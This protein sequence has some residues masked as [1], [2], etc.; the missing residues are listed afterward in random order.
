MSIN[1][2]VILIG[3]VGALVGIAPPYLI[4]QTI[5]L[6]NK[7]QRIDIMA[8]FIACAL[9]I[10]S[11]C[12]RVASHLYAQRLTTIT[13]K[14]LK[15]KLTKAIIPKTT[16]ECYG[17]A[18]DLI[19]GD[20][21]GSI[22]L[23]HNIYLD[24]AA[25]LSALFLALFIVFHYNPSLIVAPLSAILYIV[26]LK[27]LTRK[28]YLR[29]YE[30][31]V[32]MHTQLISRISISTRPS[33]LLNF[34]GLIKIGRK[35]QI[36][37]LQSKAKLALLELTSNFSYLIGITLLFYIGSYSIANETLSIGDFVSAAIYLERILMPTATLVSIYY[38][39]GEARY[40]RMRIAR[41]LSGATDG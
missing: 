20:V 40:R 33:S 3:I 7:Y 31:Y 25:S 37:S 9:I 41:S 29:S 36:L 34:E 30:K 11:P 22:Y 23:Y 12:V 32:E 4:G 28:P 13:R 39:T 38:S 15:T 17:K 2:R 1:L 10:A 19:D 16:T 24:I 14:K 27:I 18:I 21:E 8:I 26:I 35:I 6:Y 5:N